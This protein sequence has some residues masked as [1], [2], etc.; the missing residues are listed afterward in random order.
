MKWPARFLSYKSGVRFTGN[1]FDKPFK[2]LNISQIDRAMNATYFDAASIEMNRDF[3]LNGQR[4]IESDLVSL[5]LRKG[6]E[7]HMTF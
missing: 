4:K 5:A 3:V 6:Q 1:T 2:A 7:M